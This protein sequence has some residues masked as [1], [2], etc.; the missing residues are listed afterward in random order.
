MP[1]P[2]KSFIGPSARWV[3]DGD[4]T[5]EHVKRDVAGL[6][7]ERLKDRIATLDQVDV[8]LEDVATELR[9]H[10]AACAVDGN[11][12]FAAELSESL[13]ELLRFRESKGTL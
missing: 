2:K 11:L 5:F 9:R 13:W 4:A 12:M 8:T 1:T 7:R 6:L 3:D 10:M